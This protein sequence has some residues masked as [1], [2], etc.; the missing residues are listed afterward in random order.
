[1]I[2]ALRHFK[3]NSEGF[4]INNRQRHKQRSNVT[5]KLI[6]A[7]TTTLHRNNKRSRLDTN[8]SPSI[9]HSPNM[10]IYSLTF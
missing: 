7:Q 1:M 5:T 9:P 3:S 4:I 10:T 8:K 6:L 2:S